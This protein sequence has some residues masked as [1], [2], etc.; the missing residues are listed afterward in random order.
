MSGKDDQRPPIF[1][2]SATCCATPH[3][4]PADCSYRVAWQI[5]PHMRP[6]EAD[7][8]RAGQQHAAL[9]AMLRELGAEV[10]QLP[11]VH[12]AFDSVFPKD[13]A[14]LAEHRGLRFALLARFDRPERQEEE[15]QRA[16]H[17]EALGFTVLGSPPVPLEGGDVVRLGHGPVLLGHGFRS[18]RSAAPLLE[19]FLEREVLPIELVDPWLYHLDTALTALEDGTVICCP[20]AFSA[21]SLRDLERHPAVQ[22]LR[23][24][25]REEACRFALNVVQ[26]GGT[27]LTGARGTPNTTRLLESRGL[28][29]REVDLSQFH[30]AGGSAACMVGRLY[31]EARVATS[32]TTAIRSTSPYAGRS[33]SS[34]NTS[35]SS[36]S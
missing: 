9:V 29:V 20:D 1:V 17:L 18:R 5:N 10:L 15:V 33:S 2:V 19:G 30:L 21:A 11:F 6:G 31:R 35:G 4:T 12:G 36:S 13:T 3:G 8:L 24:V 16:L 26:V 22:A 23:F 14:I 25:P 27:V 28:C 32:A 34:P 7:P